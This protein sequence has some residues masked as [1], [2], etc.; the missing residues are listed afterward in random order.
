MRNRVKFLIG[1]MEKRR[2]QTLILLFVLSGYSVDAQIKSEQID[3]SLVV[4]EVLVSKSSTTFNEARSSGIVNLISA[5]L[6]NKLPVQS[7]DE[8][9]SLL[10]GVNSNRTS[11]VSQM[12]T[13]VSLR[14]LA[15]DEQGRTLV[16]MDG[17]PINTSDNGTVNWNAVN[18]ANVAKIELLKGAASALY[19]ANAIG[20]VINI[21]SK[22]ASS[23]LSI[24]GS[25]GY[26]TLNSWQSRLSLSSMISKRISLFIGGNYSKSDGYINVSD[27][28]ITP[29]TYPTY[30]HDYG[31]QTKLLYNPAPNWE[32]GLAYSLYRDKRGEGEK[33][34][35]PNGEYRRFDNDMVRISA[36]SIGA[37]RWGMAINA[38][39]QKERY[40][41]L[42]ERINGDNYQRFDVRANRKDLG[43]LFNSWYDFNFN[44]LS[45]GGEMRGG[46]VN[47]GDYYKTGSDTVLNS[48]DLD[49]Y[50]FYLRNEQRLFD[51]KLWLQLALRF[52][53]AQFHSGEF[54]AKGSGVQSFSNYNGE[55]QE[56]SWHKFS[57]N[58][59]I[60]YTPSDKLTAYFTYGRGFRASILDDLCRSGWMWIGPKIANPELGPEFVDN[61][62]F[63]ATIRMGRFTFDKSFYYGIGHDFLYYVPTGEK[64]YGKR[65]IFIRKN[66]SKVEFYG[67][68]S[69]ITYDNH[70]GLYMN[71]NYSLSISK[72][73]K[74]TWNNDLRGKQLTY[75]PKFMLKFYTLWS[76]R[77][78]EASFKATYKSKQYVTE[79]NSQYVAGFVMCDLAVAKWF[80]GRT[81]GLR[82]EVLNIFDRK[83]TNS[84]DYLSP[85]RLFNLKIMLNI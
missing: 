34:L 53:Y 37:N 65:D 8:A 24:M 62:E 27:S 19:G 77:L 36:R 14:G 13:T 50:S 18:P 74:A 64:I 70:N 84:P 57:P 43:L 23:P 55:L 48:G 56:K 68:E 17:V 32:L 28:L 1:I 71:L 66:I 51:D 3:T 52:D 39:Y 15:G 2:K 9:L 49:I 11:G 22:R 45:L 10:P 40:F 35:A 12:V 25:A 42:D 72:I 26:G 6:L 85:G 63:G 46:S 30:M 7:V 67:G 78:G 4:C 47:G 54:W 81:F 31:V 60:R 73:V 59:S 76:G 20:G 33:I 5:E 16:L 79:D 29:Y 44:R 80:W 82:G 41:K 75:A 58:L 83:E 61:F 21:V 69:A 38:Y